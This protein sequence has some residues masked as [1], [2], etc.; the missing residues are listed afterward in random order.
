MT[1]KPNSGKIAFRIASTGCGCGIIGAISCAALIA[2]SS[3]PKQMGAGYEWIGF[4]ITGAFIFG[5]LL[6][7]FIGVVLSSILNLRKTK[8]KIAGWICL[9]T[10]VLFVGLL[11]YMFTDI[12]LTLK[13]FNPKTLS[14]RETLALFLGII[15]IFIIPL[16]YS[17][18][19]LIQSGQQADD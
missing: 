19:R 2:L 13:D 7:G 16:F 11:Y 4:F 3:S 14:G 6:S 17:G 1:E 10:D 5:G 12:P 15:I 8:P 18:I 9:I